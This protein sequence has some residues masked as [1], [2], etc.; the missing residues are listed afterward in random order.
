LERDSVRKSRKPKVEREKDQNKSEM[1]GKGREHAQALLLLP[2]TRNPPW[3]LMFLLRQ[4]NRKVILS[5]AIFQYSLL[6]PFLSIPLSLSRGD[7][8]EEPIGDAFVALEAFTNEGV[9]DVVHEAGEVRG[10]E[11]AGVEHARG[12]EDEEEVGGSVRGR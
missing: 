3:L 4:H 7:T 2:L 8:F 6:P 10:G 1:T 5:P 9:A 12:R 11:E